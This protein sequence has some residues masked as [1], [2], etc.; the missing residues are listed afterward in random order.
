MSYQHKKRRSPQRI[1]V[2]GSMAFYVNMLEQKQHLRQSGIHA[3]IPNIDDQLMEPISEEIHQ[4]A[5]RQASMR[6]IRRIRDEKTFAIL[7]VNIDKYGIRDY[8]G[9]NSFAEIAIALAHYKRIYLYQGIPDFYKDELL[10]WQ[11]IPLEGNL[12]RLISD[13]RKVTS[14]NEIQLAL[15]DF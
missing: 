7:V 9:P 6:H 10:S 15:F 3:L 8:I 12:S 2:C 1:V 4:K 5:K 14:A 11:V 13:Y